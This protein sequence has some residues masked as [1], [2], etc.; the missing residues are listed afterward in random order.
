[1]TP[2]IGTSSKRHRAGS[3]L[4]AYEKKL[5]SP[6][7]MEKAIRAAKKMPVK[8]A[9]AIVDNYAFQPAGGP[10]LAPDSDPRPALEAATWTLEDV[11]KASLEG[12][13]AFSTWMRSSRAG[14][15]RGASGSPSCSVSRSGSGCSAAGIIRRL[16]SRF[17]IHGWM[18]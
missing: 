12:R 14:A 1:L 18:I 6:A 17:K 16:P 2:G 7:K 5:K 4:D 11:L 10:K 15:R 13:T 8:E 3:T 9:K